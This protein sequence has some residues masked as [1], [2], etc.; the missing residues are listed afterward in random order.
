MIHKDG[1]NWQYIDNIQ[2]CIDIIADK[3]FKH[4][5]I[6]SS[7]VIKHVFKEELNIMLNRIR[8]IIDG[9]KSADYAYII[10]T[11]QHIIIKQNF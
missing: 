9:I 2:I 10:H 4:V 5:S 7:D 3:L 11:K 8:R 1:E 6:G